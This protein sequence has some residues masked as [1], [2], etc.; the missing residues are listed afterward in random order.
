MKNFF[1][2]ISMLFILCVATLHTATAQGYDP[3]EYYTPDVEVI[4]NL[5]TNNGLQVTP[6]APQEWETIIEWDNSAPKRI[7]SIRVQNMNLTGVASFTGLAH[8]DYL[9]CSHNNLTEVLSLSGFRDI[10]GYYFNYLDCSYNDLTDID[11]TDCEWIRELNCSHNKLTELSLEKYIY[12][13]DCS[14][15]DLTTLQLPH[16]GFFDELICSNN[17]LTE[18]NIHALTIITLDCRNNSLTHVHTDLDG[19]AM[20][21]ADGQE[22]SLTLYRNRIGT[23]SR[24]IPL[25]NPR[26]S[27]SAISY[28]NGKL[29]SSNAMLYST[30][31]TIKYLDQGSY[32]NEHLSGTMNFTYSEE[33]EPITAI[34]RTHSNLLNVY[35]NSLNDILVVECE[36]FAP[37]TTIIYTMFGNRVLTH[38]SQGSAEI[39]VSHLPTG[40]YIVKLETDGKV[41][42]STKIIK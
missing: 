22:V 5:I 26:F 21:Y 36:D 17:K 16:V 18:L 6:N 15:N 37:I 9:D 7:V 42:K 2:T 3:E 23:Y 1:F 14:Y 29:T 33:V 34:N 30:E 28:K 19:F 13:F 41:I 32:V 24:T 40:V 35:H 39:N 8:L 27:N 20:L 38:T 11:I 31:F 25:T 4:N 12:H 10:Y